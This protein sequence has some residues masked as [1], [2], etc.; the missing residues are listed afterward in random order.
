MLIGEFAGKSGLSRETIRFYETQGLLER[1]Q[2]KIN[3]YR[4][5]S[6]K[7]LEKIKIIHNLKE[8]GFTLSKIKD[9]LQLYE[10][11]LKCKHTVSN[12]EIHLKEVEEKITF[13]K[14]IQKNL[15]SAIQ[16]CNA[17]PNKNTC[18][19]LEGLRM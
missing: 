16:I 17:N 3:N 2:Q 4:V 5:Y 6:E 13:L 15:K 8:L 10:S 9:I 1:N 18:S 11:D 12:F 14:D 19:I 7:D